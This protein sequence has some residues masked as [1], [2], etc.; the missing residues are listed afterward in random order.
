[1]KPTLLRTQQGAALM[2]SLV[3]LL[4]LTVL[5]V[6]ALNTTTLEERMAMNSQEISRALQAAESALS[7]AFGLKVLPGDKEEY[8]SNT[9]ALE[10]G[11]FAAGANY[12]TS[13]VERTEPGRSAN[14]KPFGTANQYSHYKNAATGMSQAEAAADDETSMAEGDNAVKLQITGG[15]YQVGPKI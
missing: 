13:F 6:S 7:S 5:G 15:F 3:M 11:N 14:G 8:E 10:A 2:I 4:V 1:M 9:G 12:T